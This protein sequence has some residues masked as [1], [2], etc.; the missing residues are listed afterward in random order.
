LVRHLDEQHPGRYDERGSPT[1]AV[2]AVAVASTVRTRRRRPTDSTATPVVAWPTKQDSVL[3][4]FKRLRGRDAAA[5]QQ[6]EGVP[7]AARSPGSMPLRSI[8]AQPIKVPSGTAGNRDDIKRLVRDRDAE[9][10]YICPR[11]AARVKGRNL[12]RHMDEQHPW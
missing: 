5:S 4:L 6:G 2:K 9:S 8:P 10:V 1:L 7:A 11:C 3:D 12:V